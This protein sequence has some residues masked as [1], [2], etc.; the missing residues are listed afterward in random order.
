MNYY[1]YTI[2]QDTDRNGPVKFDQL[3]AQYMVGTVHL[4]TYVW[5]KR[6]GDQW[7]KLKNHGYVQSEYHL[8]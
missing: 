8:L 5:H 2:N 7:I 4:E 1:Y 6:M 3:A